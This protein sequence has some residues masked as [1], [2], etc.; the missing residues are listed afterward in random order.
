MRQLNFQLHYAAEVRECQKKVAVNADPA[1]F[2]R[3]ILIAPGR[4]F[5]IHSVIYKTLLVIWVPMC[6][7]LTLDESNFFFFG[8]GTGFF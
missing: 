3:V 4:Y 1:E 2:A 5:F 7:L 6:P 8:G